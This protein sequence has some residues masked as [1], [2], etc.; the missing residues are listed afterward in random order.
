M[1]PLSLL[2]REPHE[3]GEWPYSI[4][5]LQLVITIPQDNTRGRFCQFDLRR[6]TIDK[7]VGIDGDPPAAICPQE[8][9]L[10]TPMAVPS[11]GQEKQSVRWDTEK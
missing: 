10:G 11:S 8:D 7:G 9:D 2:N 1:W 3:E 4:S 6:R 5:I